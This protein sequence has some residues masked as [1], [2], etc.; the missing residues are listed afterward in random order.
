MERTKYRLI[1]YITIFIISLQSTYSNAQTAYQ[2]IIYEAYIDGQMN[3]WASVI[4]TMENSKLPLTIS[5]KLELIDYYYGYSAFLVGKKNYTQAEIVITKGESLIQEVLLV[6]KNNA[7]AYAFKGSFLG[8]RISISKFKALYLGAE[9]LDNINKALKL[10]PNNTQGLIDKG[11]MLVHTPSVFGGDK[12]Q[13]LKYFTKAMQ[14]F[15]ASNNTV[16]NWQ[17]LNVVV[18]VARNYEKLNRL[19]DAKRVYEKVLRKEPNFTWV[20]NELYPGVLAKI[21]NK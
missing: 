13:S 4:Y 18:N 15:E 7:T 14:V 5:Q 20:K 11:N 12:V 9:S 1:I 6:N 21:R 3:K 2:K 8:F 19:E 16:Q 10:E 17:Y